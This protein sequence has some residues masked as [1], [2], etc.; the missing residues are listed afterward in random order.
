MDKSLVFSFFL[1]YSVD[2]A[3]SISK[4][5]YTDLFLQV[6]MVYYLFS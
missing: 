6:S 3:Y 2:D 1:V 5:F 4:S